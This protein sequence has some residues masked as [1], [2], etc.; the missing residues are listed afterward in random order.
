MIAF[1][2]NFALSVQE[3]DYLPVFLP[4]YTAKERIEKSLLFSAISAGIT[5]N[6]HR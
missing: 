4:A 1:F 6:P 5:L 2:R 3:Y